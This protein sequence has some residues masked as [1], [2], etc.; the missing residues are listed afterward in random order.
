MT[1]NDA[2]DLDGVWDMIRGDQGGDRLP[3]VSVLRARMTVADGQFSLR[4]GAD[5]YSGAF[6]PGRAEGFGWVD[7]VVVEGPNRGA[8][9]LGL[10]A[11]DGSRLKVGVAPPGQKR[12][13][14]L[15]AAEF[16]L[17]WEAVTVCVRQPTPWRRDGRL[18]P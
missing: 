2:R 16:V 6:R 12:P 1:S 5:V 3:A 14:D 9:V 7:A 18:S 4:I 10:Y 15:A 17:V 13:L 8:L 11:W